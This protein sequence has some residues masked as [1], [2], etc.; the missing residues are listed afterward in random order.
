ML[1]CHAATYETV[2]HNVDVRQSASSH[3]IGRFNLEVN[4]GVWLAQVNYFW[5]PKIEKLWRSDIGHGR[6]SRCNWTEDETYILL[7]LWK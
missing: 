4:T 6:F 7:S 1:P 3:F 2:Q 5:Q